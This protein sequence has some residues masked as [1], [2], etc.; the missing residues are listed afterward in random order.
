VLVLS[1]LLLPLLFAT[2]GCCRPA[3]LLPSLPLSLLLRVSLLEKL[4]PLAELPFVGTPEGT[5]RGL[6]S[7]PEATLC[8]GCAGGSRAGC[9]ALAGVAASDTGGTGSGCS[10]EA[11]LTAAFDASGANAGGCVMLASQVASAGGIAVGCSIGLSAFD[12]DSVDGSTALEPPTA[13]KG[14]LVSAEPRG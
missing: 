2:V 8:E 3:M 11:T 4:G 13:G 14:A 7:T 10:T 5:N 1:S 9:V 12:A 6:D